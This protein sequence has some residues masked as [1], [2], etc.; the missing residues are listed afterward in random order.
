MN[1]VR[2]KS[3]KN[4]GHGPVATVYL[5]RRLNAG[6]CSGCL[7]HSCSYNPARVN[8]NLDFQENIII[9]LSFSLNETIKIPQQHRILIRVSFHVIALSWDILFFQSFV[10][11]V[12]QFFSMVTLSIFMMRCDAIDANR[13]YALHVCSECHWLTTS[14]W[15]PLGPGVILDISCIIITLLIGQLN[16]M[17]ASEWLLRLW[18]HLQLAQHPSHQAAHMWWITGCNFK[19]SDWVRLSVINT[20]ITESL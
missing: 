17:K 4:I 9:H 20:E 5:L 15:L 19:S 16:A 13:R 3:I 18:L 2:T 14:C 1:F 6:H 8:L 11:N 12:N 10:L 7:H